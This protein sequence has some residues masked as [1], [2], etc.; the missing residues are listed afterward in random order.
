MTYKTGVPE[1]TLCHVFPT[2]SKTV[3]PGQDCL[4]FQVQAHLQ[5]YPVWYVCDTPRRSSN[6][7]WNGTVAQVCGWEWTDDRNKAKRL[8]GYWQ[9]LFLAYCRRDESNRP[10]YGVIPC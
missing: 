8:T 10:N 1:E 4:G 3:L 5:G 7:A 9:K 6:S 2:A